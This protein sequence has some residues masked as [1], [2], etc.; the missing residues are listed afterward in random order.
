[1]FKSFFFHAVIEKS[2][3]ELE[4][5]HLSELND[6][7][8]R[9]LFFL[10]SSIMLVHPAWQQHMLGVKQKNPRRNDTA[11]IYILLCHPLSPVTLSNKV[12]LLQSQ[13]PIAK[14]NK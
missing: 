6:V 8:R 5:H 9:C 11:G 13:F 10:G 4:S 14:I 7:F 1:M 12:C 3:H 2:E